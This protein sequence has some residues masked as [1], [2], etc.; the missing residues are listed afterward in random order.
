MSALKP[1]P[2]QT[3]WTMFFLQ[4][5]FSLA[6]LFAA[7]YFHSREIQL[8]AKQPAM[9]A[10][11]E[12]A[13][14]HIQTERDIER[15]RAAAIHIQDASDITWNGLITMTKWLDVGMWSLFL[16]SVGIA[17]VGGCTV[18]AFRVRPT[19][20]KIKSSEPSTMAATSSTT[21]SMPPVDGDSGHR[22]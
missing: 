14:T 16:S 5:A 11:D 8:L 10:S 21:R 18:F 4:V 6:L 7:S 22:R 17:G 3:L 13:R 9:Q 2:G 20:P 12:R 1:T 15:L 19:Q